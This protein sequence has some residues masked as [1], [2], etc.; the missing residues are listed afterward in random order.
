MD[1]WGNLPF[2]VST[3]HYDLGDFDKCMDINIDENELSISGQYCLLQY[4]VNGINSFIELGICVPNSCSP[5]F[6][7]VALDQNQTISPHTA[8][9]IAVNSCQS[10]NDSIAFS[11]LDII[12]M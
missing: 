1:S 6:I 9:E 10:G 4:K 11:V 12:V 2:D 3:D 7:R 5:E 8:Y